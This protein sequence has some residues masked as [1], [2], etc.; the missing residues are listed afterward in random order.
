MKQSNQK[1]VDLL[2]RVPT[3]VYIF[4]ASMVFGHLVVGYVIMDL[5]LYSGWDGGQRIGAVVIGILIFFFRRLCHWG[6]SD[7]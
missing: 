5:N 4:L 7:A 1:F 2:K 6:T 3:V